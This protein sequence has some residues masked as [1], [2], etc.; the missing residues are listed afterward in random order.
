M[1]STIR[2]SVLRCTPARRAP[3][4]GIKQHRQRQDF[5]QWHHDACDEHQDGDRPGSRL[6]QN[7]HAAHDGVLFVVEESSCG[8]YRQEICRHI[9]HGG[10]NDQ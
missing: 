7:Q 9:E 2:N 6:Q 1:N 5:Q 8:H 4:G 10:C 3:P